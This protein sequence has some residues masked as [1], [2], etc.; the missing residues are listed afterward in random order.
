M[1][2]ETRPKRENVSHM[3]LNSLAMVK[4]KKCLMNVLPHS[5]KVLYGPTR[6][7]PI[8]YLPSHS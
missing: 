7:E 5:L 6:L 8:K 2:L 1:M 3:Q 4:Y